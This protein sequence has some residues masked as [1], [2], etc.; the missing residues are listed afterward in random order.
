MIALQGI[1]LGLVSLGTRLHKG[2]NSRVNLI[3]A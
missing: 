3:L 1:R 2:I